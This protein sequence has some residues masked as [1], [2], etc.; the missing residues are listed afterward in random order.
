M[1]VTGGCDV[2][3]L[4]VRLVAGSVEGPGGVIAGAIVARQR[5]GRMVGR[6]NLVDDVREN[7][8]VLAPGVDAL[9]AIASRITTGMQHLFPSLAMILA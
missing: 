6:E 2:A 5:I 7:A 9:T 3:A 1:G 4:P 8:H